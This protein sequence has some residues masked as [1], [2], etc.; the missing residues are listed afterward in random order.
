MGDDDDDYYYYTHSIMDYYC[1]SIIA[2]IIT[3]T[4]WS[5][6]SSIFYSSTLPKLRG[7]KMS[8]TTKH[9]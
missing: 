8:E 4:F 5:L 9:G 2:I 3:M 7:W 1:L 6:S